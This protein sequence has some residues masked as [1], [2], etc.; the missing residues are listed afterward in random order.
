MK[1]VEKLQDKVCEEANKDRERIE[2]W[3]DNCQKNKGADPVNLPSSTFSRFHF[4]NNCT[5]EELIDYIEPLAGLTRH[6][7]YCLKVCRRKIVPLL[8]I[9]TS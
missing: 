9:R 8:G 5:G 2:E 3:V 7:Y 6:P 1:N 4:A